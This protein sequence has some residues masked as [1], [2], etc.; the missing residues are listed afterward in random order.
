MHILTVCPLNTSGFSCGYCNDGLF[1][2]PYDKYS[3]L[4]CN[5]NINGSLNML[6]SFD[7]ICNCKAGVIGKKCSYCPAGSFPFPDCNNRGKI[8]ISFLSFL[9]N[10]Y[11]SP[12]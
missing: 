9:S 11:F 4:E 3:C 7:G 8:C 2:E 1:G 12:I 10:V 6:C 5:C